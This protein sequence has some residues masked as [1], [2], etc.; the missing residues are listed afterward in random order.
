ML[1]RRLPR[2]PLDLVR[3]SVPVVLRLRCGLCHVHL[4]QALRKVRFY[5]LEEADDARSRALRCR[6]RLTLLRVILPQ[7]LQRHLHPLQARLHLRLV[8]LVLRLLVRPD[9]RRLCL[10]LRELRQRS[11]CSGNLLLELHRPRRHGV[12]LRRELVHLCGLLDALLI[13]L[14]HLLVAVGLVRRV[15]LRVTLQRHNHV[16]NQLLHLSEGVAACRSTGAHRRCHAACELCQ[17]LRLLAAGETPHEAHR[18]EVGKIRRRAEAADTSHGPD[19]HERSLAQAVGELLRTTGH[20]TQH[21]LGLRH[22]AQLL[23]SALDLGLEISGLGLAILLQSAHRLLVRR[24]VLRRCLQ[25]PLVAGL[26]LALR[27]QALLRVAHGLVAELHLVLQALLEHLELVFRVDLLLPRVVQLRLGLIEQPLQGL[28]DAP[29]VALVGRSGRG[30]GF[31]AVVRLLHQSRQLLHVLGPEHGG[32]DHGLQSVQEASGLHRLQH[33][34][35]TAALRLALKQADGT[36]QHVD[37]LGELLLLGGEVRLLLGADLRRGRQV[38]LVGREGGC[39]VL[40]LALQGGD[41]TGGPA[42]GRRELLDLGLAGLDLKAQVRVPL[43]APLPDLVEGLLCGLALGDDL[44]LQVPEQ[45]QHLLHGRA[46]GRRCGCDCSQQGGPE[47]LH[48]GTAPTPRSFWR[49]KAEIA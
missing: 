19:L 5:H 40:D 36:G 14:R 37:N 41:L 48:F 7:H 18:L 10:R 31:V 1:H 15:S 38:R 43:L 27:R 21:L 30:L 44:P 42:D 29:A 11:L 35:T 20:L 33:R 39:G 47:H 26:A 34:R 4:R 3:A 16:T 22:R 12:D 24:Q 9:L 25:L 13:G 17:G 8:L 45:L 23:P 46:L 28:D 6:V 32:V 49:C 2:G